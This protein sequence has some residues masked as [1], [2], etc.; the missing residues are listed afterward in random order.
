MGFVF[1]RFQLHWPVETTLVYSGWNFLQRV[2]VGELLVWRRISWVRFY[3]Y[4]SFRL[5]PQI[6]PQQRDGALLFEF[7]PGLRIRRCE[8]SIAGRLVYSEQN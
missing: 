8:L 2:W 1:R 6:D 4:I 7:R 5:P 3:P